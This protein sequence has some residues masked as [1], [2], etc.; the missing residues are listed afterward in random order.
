MCLTNSN[1][2]HLRALLLLR[3]HH[4]KRSARK[5][6]KIY[7]QEVGSDSHRIGASVLKIK[8]EVPNFFWLAKASYLLY[9]VGTSPPTVKIIVLYPEGRTTSNHT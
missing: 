6:S 2:Q 1:Q 5:I 7:E 4:D 9:N 8:N 3:G